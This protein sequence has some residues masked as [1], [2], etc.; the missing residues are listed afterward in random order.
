M[1]Y[2]MKIDVGAGMH[3]VVDMAYGDGLA[4]VRLSNEK[5][6]AKRMCDRTVSSHAGM[7]L[8]SR[9]HPTYITS[10]GE[11]VPQWGAPIA[12]IKIIPDPKD[13]LPL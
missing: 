4:S 5:R 8:R 9:I 3:Y 11:L 13:G 7:L 2:V 10:A 6:Q 12:A 1:F